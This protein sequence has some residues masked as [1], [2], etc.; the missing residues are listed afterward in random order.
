MTQLDDKGEP[1]VLAAATEFDM[2]PRSILNMEAIKDV[3]DI[4][5]IL[6]A[7]QIIFYDDFPEQFGIEDLVMEWKDDNSG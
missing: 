2:R 4:K 5:R 1:L 3:E 7:M 6:G